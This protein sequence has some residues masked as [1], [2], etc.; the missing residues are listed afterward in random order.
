MNKVFDS[1]WALR[2]IA[3]ILAFA[4]FLYVKADL[5]AGREAAGA[6]QVDILYNVPIEVDYDNDSLLVTGLPEAVNITISGS[7]SL[8]LQTKMEQ[9]YAVF[10]DLNSLTVGEHHVPI[11]HENFSDKLNVSIDPASVNIIIEEKVSKELR[12][13]PEMNNRLIAEDYVLKDMTA[14]PNT[15]TITGAKSV[16]ES[17][18]YVKATVTAEQGI[19]ASFEQQANVKVLNTEL[20]R[21]DVIVEPEKVNVKV[22]IEEYSKDIPLTIKKTGK[23]TEGVT[24]NELSVDPAKLKVTGKKAIIDELTELVVEFDLSELDE[25][26]SYE[27]KVKVPDGVSVQSDKVKIH[28][29][30]NQSIVLNEA[31]KIDSP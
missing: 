13:D 19:N 30:I 24:I 28:A 7:S 3:L 29:D 5:E 23:L 10:V 9:D 6:D 17:I 26:G 14:S 8:V 12:V 27:A 16:V 31:E 20:N 2:I 21:L 18:S 4:L 22:E 1:V 11:Q 15:V 25:S